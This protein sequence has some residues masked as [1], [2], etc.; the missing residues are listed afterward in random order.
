MNH[1]GQN[2][3]LNS[4]YNEHKSRRTKA[5]VQN[6]CEMEEAVRNKLA[7]AFQSFSGFR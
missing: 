5:Q 6:N 3:E 7:L 4:G 1:I 2:N